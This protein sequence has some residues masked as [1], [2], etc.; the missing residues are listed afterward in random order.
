MGVIKGIVVVGLGIV[1]AVVILSAVCVV[2]AE[3]AVRRE[4]TAQAIGP[5]D[6]IEVEVT[7]GQLAVDYRANEVN[8]DAKY[9]GKVL[10][11]TGKVQGIKKDFRDRPYIELATPNEFMPVHA[12]FE[13][14]PEWTSSALRQLQQNQRVGMS[15][16]GAGMVMGD[17]VLRG[18][19]F[20]SGPRR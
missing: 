7:A 18:C 5:D 6:A 13:G 10:H 16:R 11:V 17:P 12:S 1:L 8:A 2:G 20:D 19:V 4:D 15:C 14:A 3:K 9:K